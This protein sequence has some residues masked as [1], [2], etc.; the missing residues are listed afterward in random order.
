MST[1]VALASDTHC[2]SYVGLCP[3]T[4]NHHGGQHKANKVQRWLWSNWLD[5]VGQVKRQAKKHNAPIVTILNGDLCDLHPK[6]TNLITRDKVEM[7]R[8]T[9]A[10]IKPLVDIS[11]RLYIVLGTSSHTDGFEEKIAEDLESFKYNE[12]MWAHPRVRI[13]VDGVHI[14]AAHHGRMGRLEHTRRMA[15]IKLAAETGMKCFENR[16]HPPDVIFRSH[17]HRWSDSNQNHRIRGIFLPAWQAP[18]DYIYK[19]DADAVEE[20]GGAIMVCSDG[21]YEFIKCEYKPMVDR[22]VRVVL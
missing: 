15:G 7:L 21:E 22:A 4:F 18:T 12:Y 2:N 3:P 19:L 16:L 9:Y 5:Y 13:V 1:I 17:Q 8:L 20:V 10:A 14:W 11:A 6:T